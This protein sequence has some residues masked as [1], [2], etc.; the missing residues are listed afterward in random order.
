MTNFQTATML[1]QKTYPN[2]KIDKKID[3]QDWF[4]FLLTPPDPDEISTF[5]RVDKNTGQV[6]D[7]QPWDL[8]DPEDFEKAFLA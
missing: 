4:I 3:Y 2:Y 7:F 5:F 8:P 1:I 6:E